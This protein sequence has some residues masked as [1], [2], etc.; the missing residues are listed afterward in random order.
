MKTKGLL[1]L[2]T[3]LLII[4]C[5]SLSSCKECE[6]SFGEWTTV[7]PS[8]CE[9]TGVKERSCT[10]CGEKETEEIEPHTPLSIPA[11]APTCTKTGLTEGSKC[12]VCDKILKKQ[13]IVPLNPDG[14]TIT[15]IPALKPT[16]NSVGYTEAQRCSEC[17]TYLVERVKLDNLEHV[18]TVNPGKAATCTAWGYMDGVKCSVCDAII[19]ARQ[20]IP[21]IDHVLDEND[22][23]VSCKL[24]YT[25]SDDLDYRLSEDG[26]YYIVYA[27]GQCTDTNIIIPDMHLGKPVKEIGNGAFYM[28]PNIS[29]LKIGKNVTRIGNN[30]FFST[31]TFNYLQIPDSVTYIGSNAF[32]FCSQIATVDIGAG[33]E[34]LDPS[35]F[36]RAVQIRRIIVSDKNPNFKAIDN[37]LYSKD[38]KTLVLAARK[39]GDS[40]TVPDGVEKIGNNAFYYSEYKTVTLPDSVKT[41]GSEAFYRAQIEKIVGGKGLESIEDSAFDTSLLFEITLG[42]NLKSV[43]KRAFSSTKLTSVNIPASL[44]EISEQCFSYISTLKTVSLE[45]GVTKIC[46]NAFLGS[47]VATITIPDSVEEILAS[48]FGNCAELTS[49]TL[50]KGVTKIDKKAFLGSSKLASITVNEENA[51]FASV[52]GVLLSKDKTVLELYPAGKSGLTLP[53]TVTTVGHGSIQSYAGTEITLPENIETISASAFL[54]CINLEKIII[55]KNVKT[56]SGS[57]FNGCTKL[58]EVKVSEENPFYADT[59]GI[60]LTKDKTKLLYFPYARTDASI[61]ETVTVIGSY[62]FE[63]SG[64]QELVIP[65]TVKIIESN[66]FNGCAAIKKL[67]VGKGVTSIGDS[68]FKFCT[69]LVYL[70]IP[71][72]VTEMGATVTFFNAY[73]MEIFCEAESKP[74]GWDE[75]WNYDEAPV[76]WGYKLQ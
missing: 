66:A 74:E 65:D 48:A 46:A 56:V 41:I 21:P 34:H 39:N 11:V 30:A 20:P 59:N 33:L 45:N 16:C 42:S 47:S 28:D 5:A 3:L 72:S 60:L 15:V 26:E 38:G 13:E 10:L 1:I 70:Y 57:S 58:K 43:G 40:F 67:T 27:R 19:E 2:L 7:T 64:I 36:H 29:Y 31:G 25:Y 17:N 55:G 62:S 52:D 8:T 18:P 24:P 61:P 37:A 44:K 76:T 23:C 35:A 49:L 63:F 71:S 12:S 69:S 54:E 73:F 68:A 50:G 53:S 14:H 9:S 32:D 22:V 51:T 6:H 4:V 75:E